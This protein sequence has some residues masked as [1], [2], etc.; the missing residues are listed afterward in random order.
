MARG[1]TAH[2]S[3]AYLFDKLIRLVRHGASKFMQIT[4]YKL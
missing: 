4:A 2:T 3:A 1:L